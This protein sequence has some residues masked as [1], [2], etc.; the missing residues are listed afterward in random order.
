MHRITP[1]QIRKIHLEARAR[2]M[3]DDLLHIYVER[4]TG[5]KSIR[6]LTIMEGVSVIDSFAAGDSGAG[7]S[8][9]QIYLIRALCKEIGWKDENG[10]ADLKRLNGFLAK[11]YKID[12]LNWI[13]RRT[14]SK[15]IEALKDMKKEGRGGAE[16][17]SAPGKGVLKHAE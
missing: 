1:A 15:V 5:K 6:A 11:Y 10:E 8:A 13:D 4:I 2:G 14:A 9:R 17:P 12:S 3:D 7:A 16:A